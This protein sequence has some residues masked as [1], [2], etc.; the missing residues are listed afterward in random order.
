[1][2]AIY[3]DYNASA[4][5]SNEA[6]AAV[7]RALEVVGNPSSTHGFGRAA[8]KILEDARAAIGRAVGAEPAEVIFTAGG[9]EANAIALHAA[10]W[11]TVL[12]SAIEHPSV[13]SARSDIVSIPV[14]A[15]GVARLDALEAALARSVPPTL[16]SLMIANNET[17]V[18]QPV[19]AAA[20]MARATGARI[21]CDAVQGL[22]RL[23]L[24]MRTLGVDYL[25]IS[26]HKIGGPAGIGALVLAPG[27]PISPLVRGGGQERGRRGGTE[28]L[29]GAAGFGAS[30]AMVVRALAD[31]DRQR[32]LRDALEAKI[33]AVAPDAAIFGAGAERLANTSCVEMP[34]VKSELQVMS[35]DLARVAVSAGAACSSGKVAVSSVLSA[36]GVPPDRAACAIRISIGSGT[37]AEQVER[38]AETWAAIYDRQR[39]KAA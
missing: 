4:P 28:N 20:E 21:H 19:A 17:G 14:D 31:Q 37:T 32:E 23:P 18:V 15:E 2:E 33:Q 16:V 36:M 9:T 5:V 7:A 27:A 30:A 24:D 6:S 13:F 38:I 8:R 11:R 3:A 1:M 39:R 34:G 29:L 10:N 22:G 12:C 26:G 35:F 25:S